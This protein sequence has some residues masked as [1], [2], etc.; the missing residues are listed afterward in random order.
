MK[1]L[2]FYFLLALATAGGFA[3]AAD[4]SKQNSD[5][6]ASAA[7]KPGD[8]SPPAG[9]NDDDDAKKDKDEADAD[10]DKKPAAKKNGKKGGLKLTTVDEA[11]VI[12][13]LSYMQGYELGKQ[14]AQYTAIDIDLDHETLFAA[15]KDAV[16]G[17]EPKMTVQERTDAAAQIQK[18][19]QEKQTAKLKELAAKNKAE[20]KE[21]LAEN[22]KKEGVK[23]LPSG[24]QYKVLKSGKGEKPKRTETVKVHY[25]GTLLNGTEFDSSYRKGQPVVFPVGG[26]IPGWTE[27]LQ[28]MKVGD[29]WQ[30]F[31]PSELAYGEKGAGNP[32]SGGIPPNATLVF[33]V[34]LLGIEKGGRG[35]PPLK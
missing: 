21:F 19:I 13:T 27:A 5:A 23:T 33:D 32:F 7:D 29:K 14:T 9:K 26:V 12:K 17:K 28:L 34:E 31:I 1:L 24:L 15:F 3:V 2:L 4:D 25:K 20:G 6:A 22:K 11:E 35:L 16:E 10:A 8:D 30:L 18:L